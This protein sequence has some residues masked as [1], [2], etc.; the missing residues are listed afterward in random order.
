MARILLKQPS[1]K[2]AQFSTVSDSLIVW[3]R[4][5]E[6]M[7]AFAR[8]EAAEEAEVRIRKWMIECEEHSEIGRI[9]A[10]QKAV[11]SHREQYPEDKL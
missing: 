2:W 6:E 8:K 3:D 7:I 4:T 10:W 1:G 5:E 11:A 9:T